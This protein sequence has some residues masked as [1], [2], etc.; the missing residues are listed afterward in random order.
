MEYRYTVLE[1]VLKNI[2]N[3]PSTENIF[4]EIAR[5]TSDERR[6]LLSL[7]TVAEDACHQVS[8]DIGEAA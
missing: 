4:D 3:D 7:M 1:S 8:I 5:L 2:A 6:K